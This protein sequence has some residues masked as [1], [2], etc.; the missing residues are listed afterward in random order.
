MNYI[1]HGHV[2]DRNSK[3]KDWFIGSF[4]DSDQFFNSERVNN[5]EV[6]WSEKK[7]GE[8]FPAKANPLEDKTCKSVVVLISGRFRYSFQNEDGSFKDYFLNS[9]GSYVAWTPDQLHEIEALE[10]SVTLTIRWY[11]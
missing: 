2:Q 3:Y 9:P 10:D 5:F 4:V 8:F 1:E 7:K 6:K 11:K